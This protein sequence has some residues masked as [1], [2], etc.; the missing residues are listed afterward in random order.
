MIHDKTQEKDDLWQVLFHYNHFKKEWACFNR[1][2][3]RNY[4]NGTAPIDK[5]GR[6]SSVEEAIENK[7]TK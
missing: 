7:N 1:S 2:D 4:F 6:G 5:I 3:Q